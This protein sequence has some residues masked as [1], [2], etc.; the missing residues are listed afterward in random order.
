MFHSNLYGPMGKDRA[1]GSQR[2]HY[3]ELRWYQGIRGAIALRAIA[4]FVRPGFGLLSLS[5]SLNDIDSSSFFTFSTA[6][7][8]IYNWHNWHVLLC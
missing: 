8:T 3:P 5:L 6:G 2:V 4:H 7:L 1:L